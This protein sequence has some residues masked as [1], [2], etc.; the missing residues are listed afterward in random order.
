MNL[1][2]KLT[3]ARQLERL[4]VDVIEAGFPIASDGD[5]DSVRAISKELTDTIICGLAR[6]GK[7]DV[8]RAGQAVEAAKKPRIHVFIATSDIHLEYKL[9]MSREQVL[10][11]VD[12]AVRLARTYVDDVEFSAEDATRSDRDYLVQ[13]FDAA[14]AAGASTLN[15]PDTVGYTTPKEYGALIEYLNGRVEGAADVLFSV[16]CHNDLGLAVA[17]SLSAIRAGARQIECTVN[18]IGERAGNTALEEVVMALAVRSDEFGGIK[19]GITTQEIYPTSR[20]LSS[21]TGVQVQPNKAIVGDNAFAHEAGIHQDGVLKAA[22]TYEIMTPQSI[23]RASNELVLG[24]HSGRHAFGNRLAELGFKVE[25]E[26]FER[27]FRRFKSLADAKKVIYNEDLEA[28]V[29]DSVHTVEDRFS[30]ESLVLTCGTGQAPKALVRLEQDGESREQA[31]TGVGPVDAIFRAISKLSKTSSELIQYQVHAV[32]AGL[33]A[34]GEVSVTIEEDGRRV[35]GNGV[36]ED[37]MVASAKAYV[38]ALNKLEW[39]KKRRDVD[40]PRGI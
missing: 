24:K 16:H 15:V 22:I 35:I 2:E 20:L 31:A 19:T 34:Q 38:H 29:S 21:I 3:L 4:G 17:N 14:V 28:I 27:A 33:D 25:G 39:H 23:G 12:R 32:T 10:E 36:H 26:D 37:V 18:G 13:V 9:R 8:E 1:Y 40:A 6:T 5:F 11:E 7:L 30:F